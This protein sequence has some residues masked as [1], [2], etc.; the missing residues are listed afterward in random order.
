MPPL[1]WASAT[2]CMASVDLPED[3]GPKISTTR[4]RGKPPTPRARSRARAPVG[5]VSIFMLPFSPIFMTEPLPNCFS[6]WPSAISR[7]LSRSCGNVGRFDSFAIVYFSWVCGPVCPG[8][9]WVIRFHLSGSS[10]GPTRAEALVEMD[11]NL[12]RGCDRP[13]VFERHDCN[14]EHLFSQ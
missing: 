10:G 8:R 12:R 14:F 11:R 2:T 5:I 6:I 9:F 7:A 13:P 4:P 3:S 1:R